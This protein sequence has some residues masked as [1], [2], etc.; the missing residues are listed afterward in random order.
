M[1]SF[2]ALCINLTNL[3]RRIPCPDGPPRHHT[4]P[5]TV[6]LFAAGLLTALAAPDATAATSRWSGS[7]NRI[8]V[9]GGG[10]MNLTDISATTLN[11]PATA[12]QHDAASGTWL[13]TANIIVKDGSRLD[14]TSADIHELRLQ[15]NPSS[16]PATEITSF[17]SITADYGEIHIEGIKVNSWDTSANAPDS[18]VADG[19]AF[20]RARSSQDATSGAPLVSRM[21]VINSEVSYLGWDASESYGL[22]WK[23]NGDLTVL[24]VLGNVTGSHVHHNFYG[25]YTFGLQDGQW[26]NDEVDHNVGYGFD[27]HDD[28]DNVVIDGNNVH[29]NGVGSASANHGIILSERCDHAQITNN[30]SSGNGGNG[31]MVH[32]LSSDAI[33]QNNI[34][35]NNGD[36]GVAIFCSTGTLVKDNTLTGNLYGV[37]LSVAADSN[38]VEANQIAGSTQYGVFMYKGTDSNGICGSDLVPHGNTF[39][40]NTVGTSA[41]NG[42]KITEGNDN[43]FLT[44]T[45][46][47]G[48][49]IKNSALPDVQVTEFTGNTFGPGV[50]LALDG[51]A[52]TP[53]RADLSKTVHVSMELDTGATARFTDDGGA[54]FDLVRDLL[55]DVTGTNSAIDLTSSTAGTA[56]EVDT[57]PL[58]VNAGAATV[59]V[60]PTLWQTGSDDGK[61]FIVRAD[62]GASSVHYSVGDLQ[63][64]VSYD[65]T[66]GGT[67]VGAFVAD[68]SGQIAFDDAT[69]STSTVTYAVARSAVQPQS[70][71]G[72]GGGGA[73]DLSL[74]ALLASG[75]LWRGSRRGQN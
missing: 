31:I 6:A 44:N 36:A 50:V 54:I 43:H 12:L 23:A 74:L 46:N 42:V 13:L 47:D 38:T 66:R 41:T 59:H 75:L 64:G 58:L 22:S 28:T 63:S 27:G 19:R 60:A 45:L 69:G 32:D 51:S 68:G 48:I 16:A 10:T 7:N 11:L 35:D 1:Q 62:D 25:V 14:L 29:E 17:I 71:G 33:I 18:N 61:A 21:D 2:L 37:R 9:E 49:S 24:D 72:G 8:Y 73:M 52:S 4:F 67:L 40:G 55:V 53:V 15:S 30:T 57:R 56:F 65:V 3:T 26:K 39:T 34:A 70:S 5:F 20:I